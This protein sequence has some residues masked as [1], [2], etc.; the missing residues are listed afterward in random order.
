MVET[1]ENITLGITLFY[2][3]FQYAKVFP[4]PMLTSLKKSSIGQ[5][6]GF[7]LGTN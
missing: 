2:A 1:T 7:F 6:E 5:K 4:D 3:S